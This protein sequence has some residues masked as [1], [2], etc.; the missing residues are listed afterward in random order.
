MYRWLIHI[1][2]FLGEEG[3]GVFSVAGVFYVESSRLSGW[4]GVL[5]EKLDRV[6]FKVLLDDEML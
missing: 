6:V 1:Y 2:I 5:A 3:D 4:S